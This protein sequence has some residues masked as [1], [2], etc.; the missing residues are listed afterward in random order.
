MNMKKKKKTKPSVT[1]SK[2]QYTTESFT[3]S[4]SQAN[5]TNYIISSYYIVSLQLKSNMILSV[6]HVIHSSALTQTF[7]ETTSEPKGR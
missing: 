1:Y 4:L 3:V 5:Y 6:N 7:G 2:L